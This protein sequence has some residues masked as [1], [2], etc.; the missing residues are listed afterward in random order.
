MGL[1]ASYRDPSGFVVEAR[2]TYRQSIDANLVMDNTAS[3]PNVSWWEASVNLGYE[4]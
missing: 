2:G 1:G 4:F 3:N